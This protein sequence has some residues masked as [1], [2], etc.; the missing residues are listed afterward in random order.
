[1]GKIIE[2][3]ESKDGEIWAATLL[4]LTRNTVKWPIN[5]LYPLETAS[6]SDE[7]N[8]DPLPQEQIQ[9]MENDLNVKQVPETSKH[10]A[11][12]VA[13]D[14]LKEMFS[15]EIGTFL[16]LGMLWQSWFAMK[17]SLETSRN[18]LEPSA[19]F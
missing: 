10:Q 19:K 14:K 9:Q 5:F 8:S 3:I 15:D 17:E 18:I 6:V 1:M 4:L 2:L 11:T 13:R 16:L 12:R 7:R